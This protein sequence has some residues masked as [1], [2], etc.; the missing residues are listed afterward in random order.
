M[1]PLMTRV[2][3]IS[4]ILN[5]DMPIGKEGY[6]IAYNRHVDIAYKYLVRVPHLKKNYWVV[7]QDITAL[8]E[9]DTVEEYSQEVEDVIIDVA[10]KTKQFDIIR[11]LKNRN[12]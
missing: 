9:A 8:S 7:E 3:I 1:L 4:D 12:N 2:K 10:L 11:G 5:L 6:I